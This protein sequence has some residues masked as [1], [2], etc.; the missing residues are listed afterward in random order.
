[1]YCHSVR[2]VVGEY[3]DI[4]SPEFAHS[5][6]KGNAVRELHISGT[7]FD[8]R[9]LNHTEAKDHDLYGDYMHDIHEGRE[10]DMDRN[11]KSPEIL[12]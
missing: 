5:W 4:K 6:N 3:S 7:C 11:N 2:P 1:M 10:A 8:I 9:T 12:I